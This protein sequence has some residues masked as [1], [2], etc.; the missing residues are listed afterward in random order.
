VRQLSAWAANKHFAFDLLQAQCILVAQRL[1]WP[2]AG[3]T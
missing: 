2:E 1:D 3:A